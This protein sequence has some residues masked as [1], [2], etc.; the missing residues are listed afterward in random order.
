MSRN[1]VERIDVPQWPYLRNEEA[2]CFACSRH[3][4]SMRSYI[5]HRYVAP[6]GILVRPD[7]CRPEPNTNARDKREG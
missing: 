7:G 2:F 4:R 3:F 6:E 5:A 1:P